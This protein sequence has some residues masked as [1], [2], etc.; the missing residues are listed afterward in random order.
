MDLLIDLIIYL[1]KQLNKDKPRPITPQSYQAIEQQ[2]LA[3]EQRIREMQAA[4]AQQQG[5]V[6]PVKAKRGP[7]RGA[8]VAAPAKAVRTLTQTPDAYTTPPPD[9]KSP[10]AVISRQGRAPLGELRV[11]LILGEILAPPLALREPEF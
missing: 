8:P 5:R 6:K 1:I 11:P 7:S 9:V 2:K 10:S 3:V 4:M